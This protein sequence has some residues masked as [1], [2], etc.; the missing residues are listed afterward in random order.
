[1]S[2]WLDLSYEQ[3]GLYDQAIAEHF[4]AMTITGMRPETLAALKD[5]YAVAG[6]RGYWQKQLDLIQEA[7]QR[8]YV[9]PYFIARI[10]ARLEEKD[11]AFAWLERAY[12]EHSDHL[13]L[14]KVDPLLDS[15]RSDPRFADLLR[16][17]GFTP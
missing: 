17:V 3:K 9:Q 14:L 15:L 7:A 13:V 8:R 2:S 11:Q 6:W 12:A 4:K 1:M 10:C 5:S 16:R